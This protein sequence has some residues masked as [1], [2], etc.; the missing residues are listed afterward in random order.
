VTGP[1]LVLVGAL[2]VAAVSLVRARIAIGSV[3]GAPFAPDRGRASAGVRYA[4]TAAFLPGAKE[5]ASG[6]L[7]TYLAGVVYHGGLFAMLA[8]LVLTLGPVRP[9]RLVDGAL[10]A[11]F[12]LALGCGLGL[13]VKRVTSAPLRAV[14]VPDDVVANVLVDLALAAAVGA[15]LAP[16]LLAPFQFAGAALLCYAPLG[17]L[18]HMLFLVTSRRQWGQYYGRRG[19]RG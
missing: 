18:R 3:R 12:V 4:F 17:K 10:A 16:R 6:H 13:L 5:S 19:V 8:R 14:S 15:V 9:P 11:L 1:A 7:A 2:A